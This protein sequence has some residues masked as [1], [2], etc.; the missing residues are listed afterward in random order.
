MPLLP[1]VTTAT[2]P[3]RE[4]GLSI[5]LTPSSVGP[6]DLRQHRV[7]TVGRL[8]LHPV[9]GSGDDLEA[10]TRLKAAQH[11]GALVEMGIGGRV[12]LAPNAVEPR[13]N[14]RQGTGEG[15]CAREPAAFDPAARRV[16]RLNVDRELVD[17]CRV[18]DHQGAKIVTM[19]GERLRLRNPGRY[20]MQI[21]RLAHQP[22]PVR[23]D[24]R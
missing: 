1:P 13:F 8:V 5:I 21:G 12:A 3:A 23:A 18:G 15:V 17:L 2:L 20:P 6:G 19:D 9:P 10:G 14:E 22:E 4:K 11:A 24:Q 7:E 16:L